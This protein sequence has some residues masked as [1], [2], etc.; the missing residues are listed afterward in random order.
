MGQRAVIAG[1]SGLVGQELV[2]LL[3]GDKRYEQVTILVR[4]KLSMAHPKLVQREINFDLLEQLADQRELFAGAVIYCTL[5]TTIK[6]AGSQEA[7]ARVD[8]EYPLALGR[9]AKEHNADRFLIVTSMGANPQSRIFYNRVKG[10]VERDLRALGLPS[11]YIF[12]PSLLLGNRSEFRLG[13]RIGAVAAAGLPFLWV[14][15]MK[16]F[17]PVEARVV[18]LAMQQAADQGPDGEQIYESSAIS[19]AAHK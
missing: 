14:G 4:K 17:K 10:Q 1:A 15:G 3:L 9:L 6:K 5:G 16:R 11:L 18:A 19:R 8:Y 7:F 13:E 2:K 12:R